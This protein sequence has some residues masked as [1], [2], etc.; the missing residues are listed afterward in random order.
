VVA[1][2]RTPK[3]AWIQRLHRPYED[4]IKAGVVDPK[5]VTRIALQNASS[6]ASLLLTTEAAVAE[7]PEPKKDMP[8]MPGGG[9][10]GMGGMY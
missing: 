8:P 6:V 5:K 2:V 9:M 3:R 7:K 4:L 10:G 1:K